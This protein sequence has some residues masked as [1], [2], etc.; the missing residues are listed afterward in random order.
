ME[1]EGARRPQRDSSLTGNMDRVQGLQEMGRQ[2]EVD[3]GGRVVK[4]E[5]G[6]RQE[7]RK[8]ILMLHAGAHFGCVCVCVCVTP[9]CWCGGCTVSAL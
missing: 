4:W 3:R 1:D 9:A 8:G 2:G 7:E 5:A 6:G